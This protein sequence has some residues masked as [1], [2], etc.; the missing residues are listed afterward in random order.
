METLYNNG[1]TIESF[2]DKSHMTIRAKTFKNE[3][4]GWEYVS[5]DDGTVLEDNKLYAPGDTNEKYRVVTDGGYVWAVF[6]HDDLNDGVSFV[7][8]N[9]NSGTTDYGV[10]RHVTRYKAKIDN[11]KVAKVVSGVAKY[12]TPVI[13]PEAFINSEL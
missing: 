8:D 3:T 13:W 1:G 9:Y 4:E 11:D 12:F 5:Y 10:E 2:G 6:Q 7:F